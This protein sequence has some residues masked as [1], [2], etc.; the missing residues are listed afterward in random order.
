MAWGK[1][2][3]K[4][5]KANQLKATD[6]NTKQKY[7]FYSRYWGE[8]GEEKRKTGTNLPPPP[9]LRQPFN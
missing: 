9:Q 4:S 8:K 3:W 5:S 7:L 2:N 1:V 6:K